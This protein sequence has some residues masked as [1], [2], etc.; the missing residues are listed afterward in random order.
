MDGSNPSILHSDDITSPYSITIDYNTQTLYWADYT[1][2]KI[3]KSAVDGS[4]RA[5]IAADDVGLPFY[6]TFYDNQVFWVDREIRGIVKSISTI[7]NSSSPKTV[8]N[9]GDTVYQV[10]VV[11][12]EHQ[13]YSGKG[14][15]QITCM[16]LLSF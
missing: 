2:Q 13:S 15:C 10:Q 12:S 14:S 9:L 5:V 1:L 4:N 16:P 7:S 11:S 6:I 3:E 8:S